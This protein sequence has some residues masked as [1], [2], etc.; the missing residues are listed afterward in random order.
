M[1]K[2]KRRC[3]HCGC[4]FDPCPRVANNRY[5][6]KKQCQRARKSAWQKKEMDENPIYR[7]DQKEAWQLWQENNPD[8]WQKYRERNQKYADRNREKQRGRNRRRRDPTRQQSV[9]AKMDAKK[10]E[11]KTFSG[12][13]KLI[14]LTTVPI[15]KMDAIIVEIN[16]ISVCYNK[17]GAVIAKM[18]A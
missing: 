16:N 9:I 12:I 4:L 5:C 7:K 10:P 15:A 2:P 3:K 6:G 1:K 13:Y 11:N 17:F 8:Y 18:D 14:P